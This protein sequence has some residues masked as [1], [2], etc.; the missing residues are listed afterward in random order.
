MFRRYIFAISIL[1]VLFL[2]ACG[3]KQE[4]SDTIGNADAENT[5]YSSYSMLIEANGIRNVLNMDNQ[6][7]LVAG[8]DSGVETEQ[9]YR[10]VMVDRD[11]HVI[12]SSCD[13][14]VKNSS[15]SFCSTTDNKLVCAKMGGY[16]IIDP[17]TGE[18]EAEESVAGLMSDDIPSVASCD[19][20]FVYITSE[21]IYR[22]S[23][24]GKII[25]SMKNDTEGTLSYKN[26]FF[27]QNGHKYL[28]TTEDGSA[29][30]NYYEV[31]F[32]AHS[33]ELVLTDKDI[34]VDPWSVYEYGRYSFDNYNGII[35][36]LDME[37]SAKRI[38][39]YTGNM[40][41]KPVAGAYD[42][43]YILDNDTFVTTNYNS[44][45][46]MEIVVITRDD[47]LDMKSREIIKV[48]G[49]YVKN[50][51][52]LAL[53]AY[54]YNMSQNK[55]FVTVDNWGDDNKWADSKEAESRNYRLIK[56][57]QSGDAPDILYGYSLDY[58][59]LG[60]I[61]VVLDLMPYI[62][63]SSVVTRENLNDHLF[64]LMT[65]DGHCYQLFN[66]FAL[67]GF[68]GVSNGDSEDGIGFYS[69]DIIK[70]SLRYKY[71]SV[72]LLNFMLG[73]PIEQLSSSGGFVDEDQITAAVELSTSLGFSSIEQ[74]DPVYFTDGSGSITYG[75]NGTIPALFLSAGNGAFEFYGFPTFGGNCKCI[76]TMGLTAITSGS[77][78]PDA[79]FEFLE[80]LY[81]YEAQRMVISDR[82]LPVT[83]DSYNEYKRMMSTPGAIP[84]DDYV[85]LSLA[86]ELFELRG[87]KAVY[88][89][90]PDTFF[91]NL[92]RAVNSVNKVMYVDFAIY[93]ILSDELNSY[94]IQGKTPR[95]IASSLRSRLLLYIRENNI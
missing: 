35:Y 15:G 77:K 22:V 50:D 36:E 31:D 75:T 47:S 63:N 68:C 58:N 83:D 59:Y 95:D 7:C 78:H 39:A 30:A 76:E 20:G 29:F 37:H 65:K 51:K 23:G 43:L 13:V 1:P 26:D 45:S 3:I 73:Y 92:D 62:R 71:S 91:D 86:A 27:C 41:I 54:Q 61:G 5:Y 70:D 25:D 94:Y 82:F 48:A 93:N 79:C 87:D 14:T 74:N 69:N 46:I 57:M 4:P 84:Q 2:G 52:S 11:K 44:R 89:T 12:S 28:L 56:Q 16:C 80:Y 32:D 88:R 9:I 55:Y 72:D 40:L 17:L 38:C 6:I 24:D 60:R 18:I 85:M 81:S 19:E 42:R 90:I 33:T 64:D 8:I 67:N 66:G 49:D 34:N 10:I 53:A 21:M